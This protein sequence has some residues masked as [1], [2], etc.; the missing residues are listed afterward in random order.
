M[1]PFGKSLLVD[2][3]A[4]LADAHFENHRVPA[5]EACYTCLTTYAMFGDF[6]AKLQGLR[7]V[8]VHYLGKPPAPEAI[9]PYDPYDDRE[10]LHCHLGARSFEEGATHYAKPYLLLAVKGNEV[11]CLSSGCHQT[12]HNIAALNKATFWKGNR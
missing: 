7:H 6:R 4:H 5:D 2:D 11:S 10:C 9:R 12:V 3:S 1:E 8:Y